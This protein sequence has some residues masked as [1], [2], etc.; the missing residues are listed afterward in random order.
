MHAP[1]EDGACLVRVLAFVRGACA[2][3]LCAS[4]CAA[5]LLTRQSNQSRHWFVHSAAHELAQTLRSWPLRALLWQLPLFAAGRF[6][7][8]LPAR[9]ARGCERARGRCD[10]PSTSLACVTDWLE[11]GPP[12]LADGARRGRI[13]SKWERNGPA[14]GTLLLSCSCY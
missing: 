1:A 2:R 12:V 3:S 6:E 14:A 8:A 11:R 4:G 10:V 7:R 5:D 9:Q 13:R